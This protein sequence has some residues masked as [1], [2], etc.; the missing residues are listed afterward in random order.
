MIDESCI[1]LAR[2]YARAFLAIFGQRV[3]IEDCNYMRQAAHQLALRGQW[4]M[5]FDFSRSTTEEQQAMGALLLTRLQVPDY[6]RPLVAL[7][8]AHRRMQL[9]PDVFNQIVEQYFMQQAILEC[10]ISSCPVLDSQQQQKLL[11]FLEKKSDKKIRAVSKVDKRLIA[12]I[13]VQSA[14][15]LWEYSIMKKL[16][17]AQQVVLNGNDQ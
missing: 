4:Y 12:G 2:R 13:R 8:A 6:L 10:S 17:D 11:T 15:I 3:T 14:T 7:L 1:I 9:L 5:F 16:R